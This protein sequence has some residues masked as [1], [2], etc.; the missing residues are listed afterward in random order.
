MTNAEIQTKAKAPPAEEKL[1]DA[2]NFDYSLAAE[3]F[4]QRSRK[5]RRPV[6]K[7]RRFASAA[8]AIRYAIE[9]LPSELLLGAY[10]EV[11][12]KRFGGAGIRQLYDSDRYPLARRKHA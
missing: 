3:L 2:A 6:M 5:S 11:D 4:P 1:L 7:Y 8:D 9:E 10:L 12:E